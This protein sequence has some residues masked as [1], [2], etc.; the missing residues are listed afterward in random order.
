MDTKKKIEMLLST[1]FASLFSWMAVAQ[2]VA[3]IRL[4]DKQYSY[5]PLKDSIT[6]F[7]NI[8]DSKGER[9]RTLAPEELARYFLL[10]E[11]G[12]IIPEDR[13]MLSRV[14]AGQRIPSNY[15][16]SVLVDL[17]IPGKGKEQIAD[18]VGEL[19][20]SAPDS[21]VYLS[22]FGDDVRST[23]LVSKGSYPKLRQTFRESASNKYLYSALYAKLSEFDYAEAALDGYVKRQPGYQRNR[24]VSDRA[25][26]HPDRN[27]LF[28]FTEG[29]RRPTLEENLAF[30][31]VSEYQANPNH[32][33]PVVYAFYYTEDGNNPEIHR[34]L[35]GICTPAG[36][37]GR[38]GAY[39]PA[40]NME[41]V[42]Q[43]FEQVVNEKSY[44]YAFTYKIPEKKTYAGRTVYLAEWKGSPKGEESFSIGSPERPWPERPE[45]A[46]GSA[47]KYLVALLVAFLVF[48]FFFLVTKVA[49]PWIR[50]KSFENKYY[51]YYVPEENVRRRVCHF[52][53]QEIMSGQRIVVRCK[54][55]MHVECWKQNDYRCSEYGQNCKEGIQAHVHWKEL[56]TKRS[57]RDSLQTLSGIGAALV[58]W[59]VYELM[60][61]G[62]FK[63][64]AEWIVGFSLKDGLQE[65][66]YMDCV[67]K[68][69]AFLMIGLLLGFFLSLAFR[70]ND[71]YR[72]KD[73]KIMLKILGL[74]FVTGLIGMLAFALGAILLCVL[75]SVAG[76]AYIPWYCSLPAYVL[77][78]LA[79]A[80]ILSW[81]SS[82]PLKSAL[83]GG[84]IA[85]VIGFIV[86]FFTSS[87][88][89]WM[90][91]LLDFII[92]GG[93]LGASLV[94]VRILSERYFLVI[95][96]G[97]RAGQRIPIHK[98]MNATGGGNKVSIGMTG[99]CEIQM[100]WEK[101][102]KVAKEHA[103][104]YIDQEKTLPVIKP[105]ATGVLFNS[106][107]ELPVGKTC[108]LSN[109][110]TFKIGDTIFQYVESE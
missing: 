72:T 107:T 74:S 54:H 46:G 37:P 29:H 43:D 59:L 104:L 81:Q 65:S 66:L 6:V 58:A 96:N 14:G 101:S 110:D 62:G 23:Q 32:T 34:L 48:A 47:V 61:R 75:L 31:E 83:L 10:K 16:F 100:N 15:T 78:S 49:I 5:E 9:E 53:S 18:L 90:N 55:I 11:D 87:T 92:Y 42:M 57:F 93:G 60:R 45:T 69:S 28:V 56:F 36:F 73:W 76:T 94:T 4:M 8:L 108:I 95:Q 1:V 105:L 103:R 22:F 13:R 21:C 68:A 82:I 63:A 86:L 52:C 40:D 106:R 88:T 7:F 33:V 41:Q 38:K 64:L 85:S 19:V 26:L 91:M 24:D 17:G 20:A 12:Q 35:E 70:Y 67:E 102:N 80:A 2:D 51:K 98:W 3:S 30:L 27:I 89:G 77:F 39:M 84:G 97:I 71:E 99:E 25:L 44:D 50:S 109:G 79:V